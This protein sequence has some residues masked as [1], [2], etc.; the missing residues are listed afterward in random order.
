[1]GGA[2]D[3]SVERAT[4]G[5]EVAG[6]I[7]AVALLVGSV[8]VSCDRL[9]QKL[10]SPSSI[11]CVA[12]RK[13]VRRSVLGPRPRY[14]PVIAKDVKKPANQPNKAAQCIT[15]LGALSCSREPFPLWVSTRSSW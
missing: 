14:N 9:R 8:S 2:V 15:Y 5:E 3:Q 10:W 7:S 1:M 12:G 6:S 11:S 13:I 4:P